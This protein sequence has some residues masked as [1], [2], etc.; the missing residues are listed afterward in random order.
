M[1]EYTVNGATSAINTI[2]E[3][4]KHFTQS[5]NEPNES[6]QSDSFTNESNAGTPSVLDQAT[7]G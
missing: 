3:S 7:K 2:S 4:Y 5:F 1:T 6:K